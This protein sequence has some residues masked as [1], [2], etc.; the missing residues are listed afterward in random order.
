MDV[1]CFGEGVEYFGCCDVGVR[2]CLLDC[3]EGLDGG[4]C[5]LVVVGELSVVWGFWSVRYCW[6][7]WFGKMGGWC[8][9][10]DWV[11]EIVMGIYCIVD[12]ECVVVC[13]E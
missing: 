13:F 7:V 10:E 2:G 1:E 11:V 6:F 3:F 4:G 12:E 8:E 9:G 5:G